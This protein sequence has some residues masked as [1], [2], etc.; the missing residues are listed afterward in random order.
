M[1]WGIG[2]DLVE[3]QRIGKVGVLRLARRIL[4]DRE[5]ELLPG[6]DLRRLEFVAGRFAAKEAVAKACGTGI[7]DFLS[8]RDIEI[9]SDAGGKPLV[10]LLGEKIRSLWQGSRVRVHVSIAHS[11]SHAMAF[12]VVEH[13]HEVPARSA[14]SGEV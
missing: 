9:L 12:A 1:I 3:L 2:T 11:D 13:V 10:R 14:D 8:F 4:T 5:M 7:G 6:T